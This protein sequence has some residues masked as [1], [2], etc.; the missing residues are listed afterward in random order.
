M[1]KIV[2][3]LIGPTV[4]RLR[5]EKG[6]SQAELAAKCQT[7]GWDVS[8]DIIAAIE[9][10]VRCVTESEIVLLAAVLL[11]E[12]ASLL[13]SKRAAI[14]FASMPKIEPRKKKRWFGR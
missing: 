11:V 1:D 14:S 10:Q 7:Q 8:R 12:P 9:G 4:S 3:N 6:L 5:T 2:R 13:P